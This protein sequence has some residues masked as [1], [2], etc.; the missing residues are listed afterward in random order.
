MKYKSTVHLNGEVFSLDVASSEKLEAN[1][2]LQPKGEVKVIKFSD[3]E[4]FLGKTSEVVHIDLIT[5]HMYAK[6]GCEFNNPISQGAYFTIGFKHL[7]PEENFSCFAVDNQI[8]LTGTFSFECNVKDVLA[9]DLKNNALVILSS[10]CIRSGSDLL[11]YTKYGDNWEL[12]K[13]EK[14][15]YINGENDNFIQKR[16][17]IE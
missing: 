1:S 8:K 5:L 3:E 7:Q 12:E 6:I 17:K 16:G 14:I 13:Q 10:I 2:H 4:V 9:A 11:N 15:S